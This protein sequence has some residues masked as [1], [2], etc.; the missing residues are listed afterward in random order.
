MAY[1]MISN[2]HFELKK[3]CQNAREAYSAGYNSPGRVQDSEHL[4]RLVITPGDLDQHGNL[5]V[6]ALKDIQ[7]DVLSVFREKAS[8]DDITALVGDRLS[9][10]T[11]AE[12]K[13]VHSVARI[14]AKHSREITSEHVGRLFC[15]YDETVPR[16]NPPLDPVPTHVTGLPP[17]K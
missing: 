7:E 9:R 2:R 12:V 15:V 17:E 10:K 1:P 5:L 13:K 3:L 8:R 4:Y 14:L 16:R 6:R 11:D